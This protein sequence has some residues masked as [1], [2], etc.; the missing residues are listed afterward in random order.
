MFYENYPKLCISCLAISLLAYYFSP[1]ENVRV[2]VPI[3]SAQETKAP[4]KKAQQEFLASLLSWAISYSGFNIWTWKIYPHSTWTG[5]V[6]WVHEAPKCDLSCKIKTLKKLGIQDEIS[7][8]IVTNCKE[9]ATDPVHCIKV[10][11]SIVT[12]ESGWGKNCNWFNCFGM[13]GWGKKYKSYNDGVKDFVTRYTKYWYKAKS[14][15]YFYPSK[16]GVSPSRYCTSEHSSNSSKGCPNWQKHAQA[17]W[18][19]IKF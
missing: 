18:N 5:K 10:A 15:S 1:W 19:K 16:W 7:R 14:A 4:T 11:S 6:Q 13:W 3:V 12:A 17:I 8:S 2:D 9:L